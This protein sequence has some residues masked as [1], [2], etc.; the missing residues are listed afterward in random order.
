MTTGRAG[1]GA[2]VPVDRVTKVQGMNRF[3]WDVRNQAGVAVP[4]G[5]YQ[6][7]LKAGSATE[8]QPLN[9]LIDPNVAADGTTVADLKEQYEHN[10]RT[11]QL[12]V[13]VTRAVARVRDGMNKLRGATGPDAEKYQ[14]LEVIAGKLLTEPV[15][16]GKPGLQ[17][18]IAYLAGM[19]ARVD[20]KIGRDAIERYQ[21][22]KK[23]LEAIDAELDRVLGATK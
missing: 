18:H 9:V 16:Y 2:S 8:T 4:P 23:E 12:V 20:Q 6:A 1:R 22:L 3:I 17:A 10:M 11:R 5:P 13:D 19:T 21:V 14:Q 7:R 15:R